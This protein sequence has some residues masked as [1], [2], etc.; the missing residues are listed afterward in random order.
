MIKPGLQITRHP[1]EEPYHLNLVIVA[2][3]GHINGRLE[4]YCNAIDLEELGEKLSRFNGKKS[5]EERYELGSENSPVR[6]AFFLSLKVSALD[7]VGHSA[8]RIRLNNNRDFPE[9]EL[10][11]FAIKAE[12]ADINRLGN[13]LKGFGQLQHRGLEWTV[14]DGALIV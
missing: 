6:F 14:Q 10:S 4:Y 11:E 13:L 1:Y 5:D 12:P 9:R 3:N 2:S 8:L 7:S